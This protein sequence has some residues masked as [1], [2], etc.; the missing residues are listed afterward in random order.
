M[1]SLFDAVDWSITSVS[2]L[3]ALQL[4]DRFDLILFL[5]E[6]LQGIL[7]STFTAL[8]QY[9]SDTP[10]L[11]FVI[12]PQ[13]SMSSDVRVIGSNRWMI[14]LSENALPSIDVFQGYLCET[15]QS[16]D[17]RSTSATKPT[18]SLTG[19]I[20]K[21]PLVLIGSSTGGVQVLVDL[22]SSLPNTYQTP[23][24][25]VH[26]L[27]PHF[28]KTLRT[29]LANRTTLPVFIIE[30]G[31]LLGKAIYIAPYDFHVELDED[32]HAFRA[33]PF[34]RLH[35]KPKVHFMRPAIDPLFI[36]AASLKQSNIT[37]IILTGMGQDGTDGA[38][39][40]HQSGGR[41]FVQD[42]Q[43]SA[44]WG[45]QKSVLDVLPT[46]PALSPS[47]IVEQLTATTS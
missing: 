6:Q 34:F 31:M 19:K 47:A 11:I 15:G 23:I 42:Q 41:I 3:N 16:Y 9:F 45:M 13:P 7:S 8:D 43:S 2:P 22:V 36:S 12:R 4:E 14:P 24:V 20:P 26:H 10:L 1:E 30:D 37:A 17:L 33:R 27:P 38:L 25:I 35:R 39:A 29:M 18:A 5:H 28:D 32:F 46:T 21:Q 40:I 44:V